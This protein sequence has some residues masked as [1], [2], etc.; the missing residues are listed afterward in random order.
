MADRDDLLC[1]RGQSARC[2]PLALST[3]SN[4][5][6]VLKRL[7]EENVTLLHEL[8]DSR[9]P[10]CGLHTSRQQLILQPMKSYE[11][12]RRI[13]DSIGTSLFSPKTS[14]FHCSQKGSGIAPFQ[15]DAQDR[16]GQEEE[17]SIFNRGMC[18]I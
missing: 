10:Q 13:A 16:Q 14:S 18:I 8:I 6:H 12:H 9:L 1:S 11:V 15:L 7:L 2:I 4:G 5:S 17:T 3:H